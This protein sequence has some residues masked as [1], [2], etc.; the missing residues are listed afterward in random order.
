M[1]TSAVVVLAVALAL[2]AN[3]TVEIDAGHLRIRFGSG[4]IR[5]RFPLDQIDAGRPVRNPLI[6]G[7]GIRLTPHGWLYNVSGQEAVELKMK[8]GKT[9]RIGTNEPEALTAALQE[10]LDSLQPVPE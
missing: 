3:L 8:S 6:Y 10:A 2:F 7:W 4:L 5:K 9:Y 1:A